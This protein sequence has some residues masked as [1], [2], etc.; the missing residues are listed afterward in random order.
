[1]IGVLN[2]HN[3]SLNIFNFFCYKYNIHLKSDNKI[4]TKESKMYADI[5]IHLEV[6]IVK[7][8]YMYL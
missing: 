1:M 3:F 5:S 7:V 2:K 6:N 4:Y 8:L